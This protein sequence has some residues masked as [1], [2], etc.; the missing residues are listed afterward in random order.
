[1]ILTIRDDI[2]LESPAGQTRIKPWIAVF[3]G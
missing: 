1:M 2:D 3:V